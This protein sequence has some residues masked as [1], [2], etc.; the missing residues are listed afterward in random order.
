M[1]WD[2]SQ[3]DMESTLI[4]NV[5]KTPDSLKVE[6]LQN[7]ISTALSE[8]LRESD[9]PEVGGFEDPP[10]ND[11]AAEP[12]P[13]VSENKD[14][15]P[16]QDTT[17]P[18]VIV[19]SHIERIVDSTVRQIPIEVKVFDDSRVAEVQIN[20]RQASILEESVFS[21]TIP[22]DFGENE[23]RVTATDARGNMGTHQFIIH[24]EKSDRIDPT[25]PNIVMHSPNAP[26]MYHAAEQ[27]VVRGN[28]TDDKGVSEIKVNGLKTTIS[29]SGVFSKTV[30]LFEGENLIRV[31]AMDTSGNM[32]TTQFTI[33][34][35]EILRDTTGPDIRILYPAV[36]T[37]RGVKAKIHLTEAFT[38]VSGTVTDPSG[39]AEVKVRGVEAQVAGSK[40]TATIPL[41][42]GDNP[43]SVTAIDTKGNRSVEGITVFRKKAAYERKGKDYALLFA[44]ES[45]DHWPN[46]MSPLYD[47]QAIRM[48]LQSTYGFQ[49]ELIH[50][51]TRA[52]I[53]GTLIK[54]AEKQYTDEDQLLIFFAGHGHFNKILKEGYLVAQNTSKPEDD[55]TMESYLSHSEFRNIIDRMSCKHIFLVLDTCYSG[56]FDQRIAMR[57]EVEDVS[58]PLSHAD[59]EQKLKYMT[60]WYLTSGGKEQV[61]DGG[62]GHSPFAHELLEAL[63]SKGGRDNILTIDEVLRYLER[64][65]NPKPRASGFGRNEP[66][67]DFLF[68][69]E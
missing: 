41:D 25:P 51:P 24:R 52:E 18:E 20:D 40:F 60:R 59:I 28:V 10:I 37:T 4:A 27:F 36:H 15:P 23:I 61:F 30:L 16:R 46:L 54:Y 42:Y 34:R 33:V 62:R 8:F 1:V 43:L 17:P 50:N 35:D 58:K 13:L 55:I 69:V 63:R 12:E 5:S 26:I 64:L 45:Y 32:D 53:V 3:F 48:D 66:G 39:I 29:E 68:I 49:V 19:H 14:L 44:V 65:D 38:R 56:T 2:L 9:S 21:A 31:T 6:K 7:P 57:G 67:S 47:A 11:S 22:L